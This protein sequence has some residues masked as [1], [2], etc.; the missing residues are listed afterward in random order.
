MLEVVGDEVLE[1]KDVHTGNQVARVAEGRVCFATKVILTGPA[2][3]AVGVPATFRAEYRTWQ[4][5]ALPSENRP[6]RIRA[7][8][9]VDELVEPEDGVAEFD[10]IVGYVP[11]GGKV[12]V[13][14]VGEGFGC[15]PGVLEVTANE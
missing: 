15:D 4:D 9:T 8:E 6:I 13:E 2:S 3:L 7:G 14:A 10:V 12:T 5:E 11:P 1:F